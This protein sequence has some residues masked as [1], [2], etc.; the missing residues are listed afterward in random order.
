MAVHIRKAQRSK[1]WLKLVIDG[2]SGAGKTY[3]AIQI[4]KGIG[5][6]PKPILIDTE[7]GSGELYSHLGDYDYIR[8]L[9]PFSPAKYVEAIEAAIANGNTVIIIDS[10]THCWKYILSYKE[11]LDAAN[12][13]AGFTNWAKAK[14]LFDEVKTALLQ[15]PAHVICTLRAGSEYAESF[16]VKGN[17]KF[18]KVGTK[19]IAEPDLEYEFTL[20]LRIERS[21]LAT[22]VKDRTERFDIA[23]PF[24]PSPTT[25]KTLWA[26][27]NEGAGELSSEWSGALNSEDSQRALSE[28]E[29]LGVGTEGASDEDLAKKAVELLR[30]KQRE[31]NAKIKELGLDADKEGLKAFSGKAKEAGLDALELFWEFSKKRDGLKTWKEFQVILDEYVKA[32][33]ETEGKLERSSGDGAS[34]TSSEKPKTSNESGEAT[35]S[36]DESEKA[37]AVDSGSKTSSPNSETEARLKKA[38][39]KYPDR[40]LVEKRLEALGISVDDLIAETASRNPRTS[41]PALIVVLE[42]FEKRSK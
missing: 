21:H 41:L 33:N 31:A 6:D 22:A 20:A 25:G 24:T 38:F 27:L 10:L 4:A 39:E 17:K 37:G 3:S 16:D 23:A 19:P 13:R 11:S 7:N 9:P 26:W 42:E 32:K 2:V 8:I 36:S 35:G 18:E 14:L 40:A 29:K 1:A 28:A 34:P 5:P 15:C 30:Q 12:P